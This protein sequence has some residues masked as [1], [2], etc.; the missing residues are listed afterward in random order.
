MINFQKLIFGRLST[1]EAAE[2]IVKKIANSSFKF[3]KDKKV[4]KMLNFSEIDQIEQDRI[5]N[6]LVV[7]GLSMAILMAETA[8]DLIESERSIVFKKL[9]EGLQIKYPNWLGQLGV[10][11]EYLDL[12]TKLIKMRRDEYRKDFEKYRKQL[13][14]PGKVNPWIGIIAAGSLNHLRRG[15]VLPKDPLFKHLLTW[16]ELLAIEIEKVCIKI[17]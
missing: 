15:K 9:G 1:E 16:L 3:F 11:K 2:K 5:F 4:R 17:D 14:D 10:E 12:W 7:S 6:E 8:Y 13:A